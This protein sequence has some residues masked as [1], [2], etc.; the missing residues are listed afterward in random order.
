MPVN[1]EKLMTNN[2]RDTVLVADDHGLYRS[3]FGFLLRDR[4][5]FR[6]VIEAATFDAALDRLAETPNVELALFDLAMPGISGPEG[7][8]VV[9]ETYPGIRVAI[10]SG[11]EERNDVVKAVA[12]GLNGYVPKS[13]ADDEIVGALQDILDGRVFVPRFMTSGA[14]AA[15]ISSAKQQMRSESAGTGKV[16]DPGGGATYKSIS[17]RQRDVLDCVRRGLS[18]KEIARELDIAEGTVKIHLAALF[19]HYG[20]RNRTE[21]A[22]RS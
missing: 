20:A 4:M 16:G 22:T 5:G 17:P 9:K 10:V 12:M 6:S 21:L 13:L 8:S 1:S 15:A 7:L 19:S 14:A 3:G 11:S 18:N 2:Q